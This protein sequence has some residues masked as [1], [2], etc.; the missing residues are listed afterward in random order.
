LLAPLDQRRARPFFLLGWLDLDCVFGRAGLVGKAWLDLV[1]RRLIDRTNVSEVSKLSI[2]RRARDFSE[3]LINSD[4]V[5]V[6]R[7]SK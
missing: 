5:P 4:S 1:T 6:A 2:P 3:N 7:N